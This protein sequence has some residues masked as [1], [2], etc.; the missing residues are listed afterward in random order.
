MIALFQTEHFRNARA[1]RIGEIKQQTVDKTTAKELREVEKAKVCL[2]CSK[3]TCNK[4]D[5]EMM[6]G[7]RKK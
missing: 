5:C 2:N 3:T 1:Y 4:G 6:K 7:L